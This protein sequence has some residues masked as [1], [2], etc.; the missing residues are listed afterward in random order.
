[1]YDCCVSSKVYVLG[2]IDSLQS[3]HLIDRWNKRLLTL[4][5]DKPV[6]INRAFLRSVAPDLEVSTDVQASLTLPT[7]LDDRMSLFMGLRRVGPKHDY[8]L[9]FGRQGSKYIL[10][11]KRI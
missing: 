9:S 10:Q 2:R 5:F 3:R 8:V 1:M 4:K 7:Y 11:Y 6:E